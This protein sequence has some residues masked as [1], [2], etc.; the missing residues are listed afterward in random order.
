[1]I[2]S[3]SGSRTIVNADDARVSLIDAISSGRDVVIDCDGVVEVDLSFIQLLL[4]ARRSARARATP[5]RLTAPAS[6]AL[7]DALR[8]GGF[9]RQEK[10]SSPLADD[11]FWTGGAP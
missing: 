6:G 7:L 10:D 8:R 3:F 4:S 11:L 5:L 2:L 1:M 9:V